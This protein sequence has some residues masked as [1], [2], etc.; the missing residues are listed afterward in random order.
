[1]EEINSY[2]FGFN[3][4][5]KF[6]TKNILNVIKEHIKFILDPEFNVIPKREKYHM[7]CLL[8]DNMIEFRKY[9]DIS[10]ELLK[11]KE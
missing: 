9:L 1:M 8:R 3:D 5:G 7:L 11:E 10:I 4:A 6:L 2:F